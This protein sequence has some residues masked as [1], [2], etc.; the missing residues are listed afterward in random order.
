MKSEVDS[1]KAE[2]KAIKLRIS[3]EKINIM[4]KM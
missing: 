1:L 3:N 2:F 4:D